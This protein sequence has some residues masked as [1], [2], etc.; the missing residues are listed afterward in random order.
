MKIGDENMY[1]ML[2]VDIIMNKKFF[3]K[4]GLWNV[5][6]DTELIVYIDKVID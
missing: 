2:D 6:W 4:Q 5:D 3:E 1:V